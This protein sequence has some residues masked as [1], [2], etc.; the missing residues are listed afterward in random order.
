MDI[1]RSEILRRKTRTQSVL[2]MLIAIAIVEEI[3]GYGGS[4]SFELLRYLL[5]KL[6]SSKLAEPPNPW[7]SSAMSIY[8]TLCVPVLNPSL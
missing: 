3:Q 8:S 1:S 4:V 2:K 5:R 6:R 7:I